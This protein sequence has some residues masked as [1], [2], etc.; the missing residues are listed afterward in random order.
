MS[1][2]FSQAMAE[3]TDKQLVDI[4]TIK[5]DEYQLEAILSAESEIEKRKLNPSNFYTETQIEETK[6]TLATQHQTQKL[7]WQHKALIVA[8][9]VVVG[10]GVW[11]LSSHISE[12]KIIG[13]FGFA[14]ILIAQYIVYRLLKNTDYVQ[15]TTEYKHWVAY[16]YYI[17]AIVI[18]LGGIIIF[19][20]LSK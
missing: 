3:R 20:C 8:L 12:L 1:K 7:A 16:S 14:L 4:V 9:P 15:I 13:R 5:R 10:V 18:G 6:L 17:Y 19:F 11:Y 2:D